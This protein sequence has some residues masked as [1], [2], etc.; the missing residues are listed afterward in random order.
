MYMQKLTHGNLVCQAVIH[1]KENNM[2]EATLKEVIAHMCA[3][4]GWKLGE[5]IKKEHDLYPNKFNYYVQDYEF[6]MGRREDFPM[7][8]WEPKM[9]KRALYLVKQRQIEEAIR[10]DRS[11]PKVTFVYG[12]TEYVRPYIL[13]QCPGPCYLNNVSL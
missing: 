11:K 10:D 12:S 4:A 2:A 8:W 9:S 3:N 5:Q 6:R 7:N 1:A 13:W